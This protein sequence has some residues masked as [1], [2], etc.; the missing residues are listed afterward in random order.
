[1]VLQPRK[2]HALKSRHLFKNGIVN[3]IHT[4]GNETKFLLLCAKISCRC[5]RA[6]TMRL[7]TLLPGKYQENNSVIT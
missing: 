6:L 2:K 4:M 3:V 5:I 7:E 1:M